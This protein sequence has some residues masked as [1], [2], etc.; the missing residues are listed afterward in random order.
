[1]EGVWK[2]YL[3]CGEM[4]HTMSILNLLAA[5]A[6][7][8]AKNTS[9]CKWRLQLVWV[10]SSS[11]VNTWSFF[12]SLSLPPRSSLLFISLLDHHYNRVL[13]L[14]RTQPQKLASEVR[15]P[16]CLYTSCYFG[17]Q[18]R[19]DFASYP[20]LSAM[21]S[22]STRQHLQRAGARHVP[23]QSLVLSSD[24]MLYSLE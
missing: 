8:G 3:N 19:R 7:C 14:S 10:L 24:T 4:G 9:A 13:L 17:T 18:A 12:L 2:L 16:S 22:L 1:M 21:Y 5:I 11:V 15:V 23:Y 6:I 20:F